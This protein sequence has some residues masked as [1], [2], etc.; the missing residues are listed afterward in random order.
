M[1]IN[2]EKL[3]EEIEL[4]IP[5]EGI[6]EKEE[7]K[8]AGKERDLPEE[9]P[10]LPIRESVLYPKML[11]PLMV[12]QERLIKLIEAALLAN[13]KI[14]IVSLKSKEKE[15]IEPEDLFEI[16]CGATILKMVK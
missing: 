4:I 16:G 15:E 3:E 11:L 13:K 7:K 1:K 12:T 6:G 2:P 14:G 5:E 9:L 8:E 10:I